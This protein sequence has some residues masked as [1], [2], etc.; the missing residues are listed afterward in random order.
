MNRYATA[1]EALDG[2][3]TKAADCWSCGVIMFMLLSAQLPFYA[4]RSRNM[5]AKIQAG[6]YNMSGPVWSHVSNGAKH[7][8]AHQLLVDPARR[9]TAQQMLEHL[10]IRKWNQRAD[11]DTA[12]SG[13]ML[14]AVDDSLQQ[15]RKSSV[16]K[17]LALNVSVVFSKIDGLCKADWRKLTLHVAIQCLSTKKIIAHKSTT[18][19]IISLRKVFDSIDK[20]HNGTVDLNEFKEGLAESRFTEQEMDQIFESIVSLFRN[21]IVWCMLFVANMEYCYAS[22]K[23]VDGSGSIQYNEFLAATLEA[24]GYLEEERIAEAFQSIDRDNSGFIDYDKLRVVLGD[25]C[26]EDRIGEII[27][28]ADKNNDGMI[29]YD[30]FF[31]VF[32]DQTTILAAQVGDFDTEPTEHYADDEFEDFNFDFDPNQDW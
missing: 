4:K 28:A 26:A 24:R 29:S 3:V 18:Q 1:P 30:E 2:D 12:P 17:K 27:R 32:R 5:V 22:M 13:A 20:S 10:W 31:D 23:D 14:D 25:S 7:L 21:G 9:F 16:L 11:T 19:E 6:K 15:Y 8:V